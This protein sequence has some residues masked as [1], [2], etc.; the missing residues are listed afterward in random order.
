VVG[1]SKEGVFK[2]LTDRSTGKVGGSKGQGLSK[3]GREV[4]VKSVLQAVPTYAMG[5]FQLT[6]GQC[7]QLTSISAGFLWGATD[8]K[9]KV[10]WLSWK[11]MCETKPQGGMGFHDF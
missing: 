5:C 7:K 8:G 1:R 9:R 4:L 10:N 3:D 2:N 6:K 11:K